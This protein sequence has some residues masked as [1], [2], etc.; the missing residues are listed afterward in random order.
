MIRNKILVKNEYYLDLLM[1]EIDKVKI[2]K[3]KK[4]INWGTPVEYEKNKNKIL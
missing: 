1:N 3:V 2:I 4:F